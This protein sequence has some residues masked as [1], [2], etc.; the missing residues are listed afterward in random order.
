MK[1]I[2][3]YNYGGAGL[4]RVTRMMKKLGRER[5]SGAPLGRTSGLFGMTDRHPKIE[6]VTGQIY[7]IKFT[8]EEEVIDG[9]LYDE[10][11]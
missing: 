5:S 8:V 9:V 11:E 6:G 10:N 2:Y 3:F 7:S 4:I 1:Q